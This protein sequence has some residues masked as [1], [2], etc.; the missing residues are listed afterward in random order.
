MGR[1]F[2]T[3]PEMESANAVGTLRDRAVRALDF[4]P[5]AEAL[6]VVDLML[7]EILGVARADIIAHPDRCLADEEADQLRSFLARR[8]RGEPVQYILGWTEFYGLRFE[9]SP[10]VLIPRPETE[11]LVE[12]VLDHIADV[13][14]PAVLDVG[15]GTGCIAIAL[16]HE[17]PDA[18]VIALDV[19]EPSIRV[20]RR[21]A[22]T[23]AVDVTFVLEDLRNQDIDLGGKLFDVV[24]SNPPYIHPNEM[25]SVERQVLEYEPH[26]ALFTNDDPLEY[27]RLT[28]RLLDRIRRGGALIMEVHADRAQEVASLMRRTESMGQVRITKDLV[29]RERVVS[30]TVVGGRS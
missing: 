23:N 27:Y 8:L 24:V 19:S 29:G 20:A 9:V 15:T 1:R 13:R 22:A 21:N 30:G 14:Q 5:R 12:R 4:I 18:T 17:R 11:I 16:A 2:T 25:E 3:R 28:L 26:M 6:R 10:Q 7:G